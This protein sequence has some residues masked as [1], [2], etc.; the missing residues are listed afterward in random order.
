M[1]SSEYASTTSQLCSSVD[2]ATIMF[3]WSN[4]GGRLQDFLMKLYE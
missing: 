4:L 3:L 1:I 2:I